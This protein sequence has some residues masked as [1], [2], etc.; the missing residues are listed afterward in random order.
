MTHGTGRVNP[1]TAIQSRPSGPS[2]ITFGQ[3]IRPVLV[4]ARR[5]LAEAKLDEQ[6]KPE[7]RERHRDDQRRCEARL[8]V[9][10][11]QSR[12]P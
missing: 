11:G 8:V 2:A 1:L 5:A 9:G 6:R 10:A 12:A 7:H 3:R 4:R